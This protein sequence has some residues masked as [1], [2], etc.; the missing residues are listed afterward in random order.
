MSVTVVP[1]GPELGVSVSVGSVHVKIAEAV[2]PVLP[3]A[4]TVLLLEVVDGTVNVHENAPPLTV[5]A[6]HVCVVGVTVL[7][8]NAERA[9]ESL[10]LKPLPATDTVVPTGPDDGLSV[11]TG[12]VSNADA[13]SPA[14]PVATTVLLLEVVDGTV[15]VQ[16]N[17]PLPADDT[18]H[19]VGD[20][21][22]VA[23]LNVK[24]NAVSVALKPL[25]ATVTEV[26]TE[27]C[28]GVSAIDGVPENAMAC[29]PQGLVPGLRVTVGV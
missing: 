14:L 7:N 8:V 9:A 25:P 16:E 15:N 23:V 5:A 24:V 17:A 26:P 21:V 19:G 3:V 22:T 27:L 12:T 1:T 2:S 29:S 28:V 18:S 10:E 20:G 11:I 4:T 13:A 6:V